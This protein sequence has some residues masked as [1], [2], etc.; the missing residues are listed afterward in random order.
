MSTYSSPFIEGIRKDAEAKLERRISK[1]RVDYADHIDRQ[2][3]KKKY[4]KFGPDE[5]EEAYRAV[6]LLDLPDMPDIKYVYRDGENI[7]VIWTK[8]I[9]FHNELQTE[10]LNLHDHINNGLKNT[11]IAD[12]AEQIILKRKRQP[13]L[14][15]ALPELLIIFGSILF[16]PLLDTA[17]EAAS[18]ENIA[19]QVILAMIGFLFIA[20]KFA[21]LK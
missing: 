6:A 7:H 11:K 8:T 18:I 3:E 17:I 4:S 12:K 10:V 15:D 14:I 21:F 9:S 19:T 20:I 5:F 2:I 16:V 1:L 13:T